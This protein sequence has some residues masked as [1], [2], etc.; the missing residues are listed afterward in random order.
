MSFEAQFYEARRRQNFVERHQ[1]LRSQTE[2]DKQTRQP[3]YQALHIPIRVF[4]QDDK[5]GRC[6]CIP[7]RR[8]KISNSDYS[9]YQRDRDIYP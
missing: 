1:S 8:T 7:M 2:I 9:L 5:P 4:R 6:T 3:Q